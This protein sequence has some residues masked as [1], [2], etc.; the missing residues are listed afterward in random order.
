MIDRTKINF[1]V[2]ADGLQL[3]R[4]ANDVILCPGNSEGFI[5]T[6]YFKEVRE[7]PSGQVRTVNIFRMCT[8]QGVIYCLKK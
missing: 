3:F 2:F 6:E 4:S 1:N 7:V 8:V 5:P